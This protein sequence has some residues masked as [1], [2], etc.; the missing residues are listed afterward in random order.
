MGRKALWKSIYID[1]SDDYRNLSS[2][3][4]SSK[5]AF[6]KYTWNI[7]DVPGGV[8]LETNIPYSGLRMIFRH[9]G[10]TFPRD[11]VTDIMTL[12]E[13]SLYGKMPIFHRQN[14]ETT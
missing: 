10:I 5:G 3:W 8:Y 11:H 7:D 9:A 14:H 6:S 13:R 1:N 12:E 2:C 4:G